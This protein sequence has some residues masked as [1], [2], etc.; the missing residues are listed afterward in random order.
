MSL[1]R[2]LFGNRPSKWLTVHE[3]LIKFMRVFLLILA[4]V[5]KHNKQDSCNFYKDMYSFVNLANEYLTEYDGLTSA[6]KKSY[7]IRLH[8]ILTNMSQYL[9]YF[10]GGTW[11]ESWTLPHLYTFYQA[12]IAE[13]KQNPSPGVIGIGTRYDLP[14]FSYSQSSDPHTR[15]NIE[16]VLFGVLFDLPRENVSS[17][18]SHI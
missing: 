14:H 6:K 15:Q 2:C 3:K 12:V 7:R 13:V 1:F 16:R 8:E 4:S 11:G 17:V 18:S 5:Q 9:T 10:I